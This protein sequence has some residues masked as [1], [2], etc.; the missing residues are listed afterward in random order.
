MVE[1]GLAGL[2]GIAARIGEV[3]VGNVVAGKGESCEDRKV[4]V[5]SAESCPGGGASY[6]MTSVAGSSEWFDRGFVTYSNDAKRKML[7]VKAI[8]L[9]KHGAVSQAVVEEMAKG[10]IKK[11]N[12]RLSIAISGLAGPGGGTEDKPV[13]L[14][15][16]AWAVE[17][18][19]GVVVESTK[20]IFPGERAA[21]RDGA[22]ALSLQGLL[23]RALAWKEKNKKTSV[24]IGEV[25]NLV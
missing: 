5:S 16:F 25:E 14:V 22:I 15:W 4:F 12:A 24:E 2:E 3:L 10:A 7:G 23:V 21:I 20:M 6:V 9:K 1:L 17:N 13:G 18:A 8:T 11:S 19:D